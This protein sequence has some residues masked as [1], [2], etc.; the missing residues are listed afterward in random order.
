MKTRWKLFTYPLMD[1]K[2][3]EAMLNRQAAEGWRLEKVHLGALASFVP[4]ETPVCY[5]IDWYDPN[6]EDGLD[7][8]RLLTDAGW[9]RVGQLSYWN[10]YE[11]PAGTLPI[12]TDGELE[13]QRF[14]KK[15]LRRMATGWSILLAMVLLLVV[16]APVTAWLGLSSVWQYWLEL[17]AQYNTVALLLLFL[18][19]LLLGGLLWSARLV[20]RLGQW[21]RAIAL[22]ESFPVPGRASALAAR[23]LVLA[24]DLL[25]VLCLPCFVL[26]AATG[27]LGRPWMIGTIIG[28]LIVLGTKEGIKYQRVRR[29]KTGMVIAAAVLLVI[30][31][32][33]L[34]WLTARLQVPSPLSGPNLFPWAEVEKREDSTTFLAAHTKWEEW[35]YP[36]G[37][38]ERAY[39]VTAWAEGWV[40]PCSWLADWVTGQYLKDMGVSDSEELPGYEDVWVSDHLWLIRRGN[41]VLWVDGD[42]SPLD[43]RWLDG[44]LARLEEDIT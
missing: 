36:E 2:A 42:M 17:P 4:A 37:L 31:L 18:P 28:A 26:D 38:P 15:A 6:R 14:R 44:V 3:A 19:L 10:L 35:W 24:G 25:L 41:T 33:P 43:T 34:S 40:L 8:R 27:A 7:Y 39:T 30:S 23:L 9:R 1:I 16:L 11:A 32:L 13:Y 20:L 5:C 21:K 22:D 29:Y 12:Q